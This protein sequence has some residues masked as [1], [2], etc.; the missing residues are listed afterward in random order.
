M[1]KVIA[2]IDG[3]KY[4]ESTTAYAV[5]LAKQMNAH[6]VG[7][8]LEDFTYHSYKIYEMIGDDGVSEARREFLENKDRQ[9]RKQA[10]DRFEEACRDAGLGHSIHLDKSIA[11][12]ELL[13]ESIY[14]DLLIIDRNETFAPFQEKI[15]TRFVRDLLSEVQCPVLVIPEEYEP[16]EKILLLYDGE[17]SSVYAIRT[18]SYLFPAFTSLDTE[19]LTVKGMKD[20]MHVPDNKLMKELMKRHYPD[21]TYTVLKGAPETEIINYLSDQDKNVL[22]VLGAYSRG[23]ISRWFKESMADVLMTELDMPMFITHR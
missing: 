19:V 13:H 22:I 3:L 7:V 11:L 15:P 18:F 10:T 2:A 1:K 8:L 23:M 17:P 9:T 14:A 4:S 6:L 21:A 16:I 12:Q 20:S 5:Q